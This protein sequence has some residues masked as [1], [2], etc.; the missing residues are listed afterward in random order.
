ML[1]GALGCLC[2]VILPLAA[3]AQQTADLS[4]RPIVKP[5]VD[6]AAV[7]LAPTENASTPAP[8]VD[9]EEKSPPI[10]SPDEGKDTTETDITSELG[11]AFNSQDRVA[12]FSGKVKVIDPRFQLVCDRLTVFLNKP[13]PAGQNSASTPAPTTAAVPV[14]NGKKAKGDPATPSAGSG[15]DHVV[16]E[17]HVVILQ[18]KAA[19]KPGEEEKV[20]VGRGDRGTFD[21]KSGDMIL[22]G[23]PSLEQN[24]SSIIALATGTVMTI[25]RD[26]S[27]DVKGAAKTTLIQKRGNGSGGSIF[28]L[29]SGPTSSGNKR[30]N[31]ATAS[32]AA[33]PTPTGRARR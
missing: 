22:T 27:L 16:A 23:S 31:P 13:V 25:H 32:S 5:V 19:T 33:T 3:N 20:S 12:T 26:S 11:A 8:D 4:A 21:N 15:I 29:P 1:A 14:F 18:K 17:G 30:A 6:L 2:F 28:D 10:D 24:G 7:A 9:A